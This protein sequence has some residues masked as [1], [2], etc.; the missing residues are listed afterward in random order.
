MCI[1]GLTD[2][3]VGIVCVSFSPGDLLLGVYSGILLDSF[4]GDIRRHLSGEHGKHLLEAHGIQR[5]EVTEMIYASRLLFE[6][7]FDHKIYAAVDTV[8][9]ELARGI[10]ANFEDAEIAGDTLAGA[11][12]AILFAGCTDDLNS[13]EHTLDVAAIDY[14]EILRVE[15]GESIQEPL[16]AAGFMLLFE[17]GTDMVG[18]GGEVVDTIAEGIDIHHRAATHHCHSPIGEQS[19]YNAEGLL[20]ELRSTVIC[21]QGE[22]IDQMMRDAA[23]LLGGGHSRDDGYALVDLAAVG[24]D[25]L[26][27]EA[28]SH[29]N[30]QS[31]LARGSRPCDDYKSGWVTTHID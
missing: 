14:P 6:S 29:I 17:A 12:S 18:H 24:G 13:M 10:E 23:A 22:H 2:V 21:I 9:Q 7:R 11:E 8:E 4:D 15:P 25:D 26:R 19:A 3:E 27:V 1:I 16:I 31:R 20:F 28:F 30:S 5:I